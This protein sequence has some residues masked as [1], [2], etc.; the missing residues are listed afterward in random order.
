M[1]LVPLSFFLPP[2][3]RSRSEST[4]LEIFSPWNHSICVLPYKVSFRCEERVW[5][6]LSIV[7]KS[8]TI[9]ER[10]REIEWW[11]FFEKGFWKYFFCSEAP[12]WTFGFGKLLVIFFSDSIIVRL[13]VPTKQ[14]FVSRCWNFHQDHLESL[15]V[16]NDRSVVVWWLF[17]VCISV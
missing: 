1:D 13:R 11:E 2:R 9:I 10:E 3:Y 6:L 17:A 8:E 5:Y 7:I 16:N 12:F 15:W 14:L 4:F